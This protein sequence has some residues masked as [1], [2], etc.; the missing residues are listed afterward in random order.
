MLCQIL[1]DWQ[2]T[3]NTSTGDFKYKMQKEVSL[4]SASHFLWS[5]CDF[6]QQL[7]P[8]FYELINLALAVTMSILVVAVIKV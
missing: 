3:C 6:N 7:M 1:N 5:P 4:I 2:D 8:F